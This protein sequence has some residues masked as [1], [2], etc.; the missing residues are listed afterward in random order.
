MKLWLSLSP[1]G[2]GP[3]RNGMAPGIPKDFAQLLPRSTAKDSK[4]FFSQRNESI[5][6]SENE[7]DSPTKEQR[8]EFIT[9]VSEV[10]INKFIQI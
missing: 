3:Q 5:V 4:W 1:T 9:K 10:I 2:K 6:E 7:W 8:T